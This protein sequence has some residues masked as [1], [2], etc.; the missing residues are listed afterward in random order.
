MFEHVDI[1]SLF[2]KWRPSNLDRRS[3]GDGRIVGNDHGKQS[4][5]DLLKIDFLDFK[6]LDGWLAFLFEASLDG[7]CH[8]MAEG[9]RGR[10]VGADR[11]HFNQKLMPSKAW[12]FVA[13]GSDSKLSDFEA[14]SINPL[15]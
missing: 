11:R 15:L 9:G 1:D 3:A 4:D 7:I 8:D 2:V 5:A 10:Y 12:N 13:Y 14:E 6:G